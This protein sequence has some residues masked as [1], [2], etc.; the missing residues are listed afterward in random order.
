MYAIYVALDSRG[1]GVGKALM[2][3]AFAEF[4]ARNKTGML[5]NVLAENTPSVNFY[6]NL[7]GVEI[8]EKPFVL[9]D[10]TY[11]QVTLGFKLGEDSR[12]TS[13]EVQKCN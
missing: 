1:K 3:A 12:W 8:G 6:K 2:E 11:P 13:S 5:V 7:G 4:R 10:V 9:K